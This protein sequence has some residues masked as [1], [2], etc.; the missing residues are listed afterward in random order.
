MTDYLLAQWFL[1]SQTSWPILL[2][3]V[4]FMIGLW[5]YRRSGRNTLLH[6]LLIGTP[7]IFIAMMTLQLDFE[8]YY[9]GN[10]LLRWLLGPA[11]VA[12]AIPLAQQMHQV[13]AL[14]K[15]LFIALFLGGFFAALSAL[16]LGKL[17]ALDQQVLL[18]LAAKSVTTPIAVGLTQKLGGLTSLITVAV[19]LTGIIGVLLAPMVFRMSKIDDDRWQGFILGVTAHAIGTAKAFE[20]SPRCGAFST[21]GM[22]L[23]GIWTSVFLPLSVSFFLP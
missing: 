2:S 10:G 1:V 22:G 19:L 7:L 17:V 3:V 4:G 20:I 11:T 23:N 6:P 18:S 21:L 14:F 12:L 15:P 13:P 9:E 8:S 5:V 16:L